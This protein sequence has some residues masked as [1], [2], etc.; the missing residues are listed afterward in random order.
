[1]RTPSGALAFDAVIDTSQMDAGLKKSGNSVDSFTSKAVQDFDKLDK[2]VEKSGQKIQKTLSQ[3][4]NTNK[5]LDLSSAERSAL[6][7]SQ[8]LDQTGGRISST[9]TKSGQ[10]AQTF[11]NTF[12]SSMEG[13]R[14]SYD[15]LGGSIENQSSGINGSLK[16]IAATA[17]GFAAV[18][19]LAQ[20]PQEIVRVRGEFESLEITLKTILGSKAEA[21]RLLAEVVNLAATTPFGL[22]DASQATKQLI[23]Y[24][25]ASSDVIKVLHNL[26]DVA[27]GLSIPIG[28]L[29]YLYGTL[30][31][32]GRAYQQDINQFASR[33]IPIYEELAKVLQINVNQVRDFV[34]SG[35]V[36]FTEIEQVFT[37]LTS[38]GG[39][40]FNLLNEQAGSIN[41]LVAALGDK[42]EI[43]FNNIGKANEGII[44]QTLTGAGVIIDNYESIIEVLKIAAITYGTYRAALILTDAAIAANVVWTN[45]LTVANR[46]AAISGVTLTAGQTRLTAATVLLRNATAGLNATLLANPYALAAAAL[47]GLITYMGVFEGEATEVEKAQQRIAN[48]SKSI[49][50]ESARE[51]AKI[52]SL[53]SQIKGLTG[54]R[55]KQA[56]KIRELISLNPNLLSG[57]NA[58]NIAT[59]ESTKAI[60]EYIQAKNRQIQIQQLEE[61]NAASARREGEIN[62]GGADLSLI[63]YIGIGLVSAYSKADD[64]A[65]RSENIRSSIADKQRKDEQAFREANSKKII[66]L[67]AA[68]KKTVSGAGE[69]T[70]SKEAAIKAYDAEIARLRKLNSVRGISEAD[71]LKNNEEIESNL[72]RR[73]ALVGKLSKDEKAAA[74]ESEKRGPYGSVQYWE[75][76]A[77]KAREILE[78]TPTDNTK[79]IG[80]RQKALTDAESQLAEARKLIATRSVDEE[81]EYKRQQYEQYYKFIELFGQDAANQQFKTLVDSGKSYVQY[82][83]GEIAKLKSIADFTPLKDADATR[84]GVLTNQRDQYTGKQSG[85]DQFKKQIQDVEDSAENLSDKLVELRKLE[86]ALNVPLS[87]E[88]YAK[89]QAIAEAIVQTEKDRK[90]ALTSFM[91]SLEGSASRELEIT[92][93]YADLRAEV[94]KE[95]NAGRI[96][97]RQDALDKINKAENDELTETR[98]RAVEGGKAFAALNVDSIKNG[99]A[100]LKERVEKEKA[101]LKD[102]EEANL[103]YTNEYI[104]QQV[105]VKQATKDVTDFQRQKYAEIA[106]SISALGQSLASIGDSNNSGLVQLFGELAS[107]VTQVNTALDKSK[108]SGE[109]GSSS[110]T[111]YIQAAQG[112]IQIIGMVIESAKQRKEAERQYYASV[113]QY[114]TEYQMLLNQRIR[115]QAQDDENIFVTDYAGRIE[116]GV[117]AYKDAQDKYLDAVEKVANEGMVKTGQ[118]SKTDWKKVGSGAATGAAAGAA[119]GPWGA[120]IGGVVGAVAGFFGGKKKV[121][122]FANIETQFAGLFET[123]E[124]GFKRINKEMAQSLINSGLLD[125]NT[126]ALVQ[127]ALDL[128]DAM[129]EANDQIKSVLKD[130]A[131][132]LGDS[133]RDALV[134]AF[135]AG[136]DSAEA[137]RDTVANVIEDMISRLLFS[138]IFGSLFDQLE[139]E[140]LK[141]ADTLG[142]GDGVYTD[143]IIRFM[144]AAGPAVDAFN[145]ALA[146]SQEA[147]NQY[148]LD[149]FKGDQ[150]APQSLT[151]AIA[152][153][154]QESANE[155]NAQFNAMRISQARME[156]TAV[157]QLF[158]LQYIR[159]YTSVL[160]ILVNQG[161]EQLFYTRNADALLTRI[162]G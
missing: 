119:F 28:E 101:Y 149:L 64:A 83:D 153:I 6:G 52:N 145:E 132:Q 7:F 41:Q 8:K 5:V 136:T 30:R 57:I 122:V 37:N 120:A 123:G 126:K 27:A 16:S 21:D 159:Q 29:T 77:G 69:V 61:E 152:T 17:L 49:S 134:G 15:R 2:A 58:E 82:L 89:R 56:E 68:D 70:R 84:L 106:D 108:Q 38:E 107:G 150:Q 73:A 74:K 138:Q 94:E 141:S 99:E 90:N 111:K 20:L 98:L 50:E 131:G 146:A 11:Q 125:E 105:R 63:D 130:L 148:G 60:E 18:G 160:P 44:K 31:S 78:S 124:D 154:S 95:F 147:A 91:Q 71:F 13:A 162:A 97:N 144:Q 151:G 75:Y 96:K 76:I 72:Q 128:G 25:V 143:D 79:L 46:A 19:T 4:V 133:L 117:K 22:K 3:K 43:A 26:G 100:A 103:Q 54:N 87:T 104:Q 135:E 155:L 88:D 127:N 110:I 161:E 40:F 10:Q 157:N 9:L 121:D 55:E 51:G 14:R 39:K 102:L 137:F 12:S 42:F 59:K 80:N 139:A 23:A 62:S 1:M 34:E 32:Q 24:G 65:K 67:A 156:V 66:E 48:S 140:F 109:N 129:E 35:K 92:K 115:T 45:A 158:E 36:G 112:A 86:E 33:G 81:I 53:V 47:V 85:L 114:E 116:S 118:K 113:T 93:R 142:G